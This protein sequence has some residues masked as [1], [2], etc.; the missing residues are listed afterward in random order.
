MSEDRLLRDLSGAAYM[1]GAD[2]DALAR[3]NELA[4]VTNKGELSAYRS[5]RDKKVYVAHRGT[6]K[7]KDLSADLAIA[8]GMEKYHP[9]FKRA[10]REAARN[11]TTVT[12]R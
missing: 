2:R 6:K 10:R 8:F 7:R 1:S 12:K 3:E 9:R 11:A 4:M 5:D